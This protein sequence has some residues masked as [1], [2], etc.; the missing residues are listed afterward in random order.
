LAGIIT[1]SSA[2]AM[3]DDCVRKNLSIFCGRQ[4]HTVHTSQ[5]NLSGRLQL[6][7]AEAIS[8]VLVHVQRPVL[9]GVSQN[10]LPVS[11][12]SR[13]W[14]KCEHADAESVET[15][16]QLRLAVA[17]PPPIPHALDRIVN[18]NLGLVESSTANSEGEGI[19]FFYKKLEL[20]IHPAF[21]QLF[22]L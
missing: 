2:F 14:N 13:Q 3:L 5:S 9:V 20:A 10:H 11:A 21:D 7:G 18:G 16:R 1:S 12:D 15:K 17:S 22:S 19:K 6:Q 4:I 8:Y